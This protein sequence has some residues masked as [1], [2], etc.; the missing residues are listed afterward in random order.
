MSSQECEYVGCSEATKGQYCSEHEADYQDYLFDS[1]QDD[2]I[3]FDYADELKLNG[4]M[5]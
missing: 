1:Y 4:D 5:E 2:Q 3:E